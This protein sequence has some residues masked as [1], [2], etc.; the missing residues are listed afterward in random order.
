MLAIAPK[1]T[2]NK[3]WSEPTNLLP[4]KH[5]ALVPILGSEAGRLGASM[6]LAIRN[7]Q[8]IG[9]CGIQPE[10][11]IYIDPKGQWLGTNTPQWLST[12]PVYL[13]PVADKLIPSQCK[14]TPT[15]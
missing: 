9:V 11:N 2:R 15:L 14:R 1:D 13:Y 3:H 4:Y 10:H 8:L 7:N 6:P 5:H 12:H